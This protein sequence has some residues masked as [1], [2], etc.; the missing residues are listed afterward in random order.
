MVERLDR[1]Q[2]VQVVRERMVPARSQTKGV[3][4]VTIQV[5]VVLAEEVKLGMEKTPKMAVDIL[6]IS[7]EMVERD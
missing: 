5:L 4:E 7:V 2:A 3:P 6:V 1:E